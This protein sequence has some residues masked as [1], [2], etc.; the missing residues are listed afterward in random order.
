MKRKI[1]ASF[2]IMT[3]F[4]CFFINVLS[5]ADN[6]SAIRARMEERLPIILE[7][8]SKG[9]LGENSRGYLD[10]VGRHREKED[11]VRAENQDR[12]KVYTTIAQKER[13]SVEHVGRRRALQIADIARKGD[14]LQDQDGRWY[15]K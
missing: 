10:Y 3:I 4:C 12:E 1:L 2:T 8:K 7:L 9:I 11:I 15:Q 13:V 6:L 5:F 14:W